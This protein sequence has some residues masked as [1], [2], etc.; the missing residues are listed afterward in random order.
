MRCGKSIFIGI[1][2]GTVVAIVIG[3]DRFCILTAMGRKR[4]EFEAREL[5]CHILASKI[6]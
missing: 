4:Q 6:Q 5:M 1:R 3:S 2:E